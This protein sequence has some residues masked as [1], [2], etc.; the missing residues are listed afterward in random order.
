MDLSEEEV[1]KILK[2]IDELEFTEIRLE[3]GDLKIHILKDGHGRDAPAAGGVPP[4]PP[5]G[6]HAGEAPAP[7]EPPARRESEPVV[8]PAIPSDTAHIVASPV[9]GVFYRSPE[10]GSSPFV[11]VGDTV[12]AD[13][14][15]CLIEVMKLFHS[16]AA[17]VGGRVDAVFVENGSAVNEGDTLFAI[18][19]EH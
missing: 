4:E 1:G 13:D 9:P 3:V 19:A 5:S 7:A 12:G 14:T 11:R 2:I 15:V 6:H 16:V 17:G 10:P 8:P 18:E